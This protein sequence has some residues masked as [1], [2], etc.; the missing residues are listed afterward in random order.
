VAAI[1]NVEQ[2]LAL[3][4]VQIRAEAEHCAAGVIVADKLA[5]DCGVS[6]TAVDPM[7]VVTQREVV[8]SGVNQP[9]QAL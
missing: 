6:F 3:W 9:W 2:Q 7:R 5:G 1:W 4:C 8:I